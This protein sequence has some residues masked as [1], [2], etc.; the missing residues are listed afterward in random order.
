MQSPNHYN[1]TQL[2]DA[3]VAGDVGFCEGNICKYVYRWKNKDG[4]KDLYKAR[5]YLNTLI[6]NEELKQAFPKEHLE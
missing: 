6:A 2:L 3:L 5:D 1:G 4:I